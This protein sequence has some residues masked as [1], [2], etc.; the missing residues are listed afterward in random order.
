MDT[1]QEDDLSLLYRLL[2]KVDK[3]DICARYFVDYVKVRNA[4]GHL[5]HR[6]MSLSYIDKRHFYTQGSQHR[7]GSLRHSFILHQ[8][9]QH[10][11]PTQL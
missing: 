5:H 10:S 4:G 9:G 6:L 3:L 7:Q 8:K 11:G 2:K 1:R